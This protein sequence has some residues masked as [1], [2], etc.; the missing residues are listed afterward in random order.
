VRQLFAR[1]PSTYWLPRGAIEPSSTAALPVRSQISRASSGVSCASA[2]LPIRRRVCPIRWSEMRLRNGDCSSCTAMPC[3]SVL[4]KT[5]SPVE[6]AKSASTTVSFSLRT[7]VRCRNNRAAPAATS[8]RTTATAIHPQGFLSATCTSTLE[9][10]AATM[11]SSCSGTK[12]TFSARRYPR[13]G[14]VR[15]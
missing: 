13:P 8:S 3:R 15:M 6:L 9:W 2:D 1:N 4:S 10:F 5:D 7:T 11:L 12:R 14:T